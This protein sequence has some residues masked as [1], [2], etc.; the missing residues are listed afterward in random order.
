MGKYEK[1]AKEFVKTY[2]QEV[3]YNYDIRYVKPNEC[4]ELDCMLREYSPCSGPNDYEANMA[5]IQKGSYLYLL[6][7]Q[8]TLCAKYNLD[9]NEYENLREDML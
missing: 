9:T 8:F 4:I 3:T 1:E 7:D 2:L 6:N 5:V